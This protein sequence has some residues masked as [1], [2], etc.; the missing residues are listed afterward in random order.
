MSFKYKNNCIFYYD[1]FG[2]INDYYQ[3]ITDLIKN[4]I[5]NNPE[6]N[7]LN[8]TLCNNNFSFL[9]NNPNIK[10]NINYE[11]TLVKKGGRSVPYDTPFGQIDD[12]DNNKYLVRI[13]RYNELEYSDLII[14][15]SMPNI[16]NV[17]SCDVYNLFSKKHI[18]ISPS[19]YDLYLTKENRNII[20]LTTFI[21]TN[22]PRR[23][24]LIENINNKQIPHLNVNNCFKKDELQTIYK[25]TKII[26]NIHQTEHHH[27]FEELRALPALECGV[28][29]I[30]EISPIINSIPYNDLI[31]WESY[32]N[33]L[34]KTQEVINN[35]DYF[36]DL[37]FTET[38]INKLNELKNMNYTNLNNALISLTNNIK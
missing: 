26:I 8:I 7:N 32:D 22:E 11:H 35:Y 4:I 17:N 6:L 15:Y 10:I 38:N 33:I 27:T 2:I 34:N 29:V 24:L 13:D 1:N 20:A 5:N 23:K 30:S 18:Y 14:D 19:I 9:N 21:N 31:I 36:H 12:N 25:N 37:I 3:M 16:I 28:I